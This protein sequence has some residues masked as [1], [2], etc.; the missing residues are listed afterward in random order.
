MDQL[1]AIP[2]IKLRLLSKA[3]LYKS[4]MELNLPIG[5]NSPNNLGSLNEM[6]IKKPMQMCQNL[7]IHN[8]DWV[9]IPEDTDNQE[10]KF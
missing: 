6:P 3:Y 1:N 8:L 10:D 9:Q 2:I 7:Y 4:I 5:T